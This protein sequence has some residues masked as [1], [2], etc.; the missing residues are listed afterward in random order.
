MET[1]AYHVNDF[2]GALIVFDGDC[3]FCSRSMD[4]IVRHDTYDNIRLTPC[5]S[6]MGSRLMRQHGINPEDPSTF[7]VLKNGKAY[8]RSKAMLELVPLLDKSVRGMA[9]FG[10]IPSG[11]RDVIY[12]WTARNRRKLVKG[13]CPVPTQAMID[14]M[15]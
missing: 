5:T 8:T 2:D 15:V 6:E 9:F 4:W 1:S 7:L 13:A 10:L 14:R 12:N 11:L 3:I